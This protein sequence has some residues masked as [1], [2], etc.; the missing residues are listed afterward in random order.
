MTIS[1]E[2][3]D[4]PHPEGTWPHTREWLRDRFGGVPE[5]DTRRILGLDAAELYGFDLAKLAP[6]VE[7]IGPTAEEIHGGAA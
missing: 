6:V 7:R 5:A 3:H 2:T 1:D 4:Y